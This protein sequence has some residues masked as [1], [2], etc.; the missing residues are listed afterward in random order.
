LP[1]EILQARCGS[2]A[3]HGHMNRPPLIVGGRLGEYGTGAFA[4][5]GALTA[6]RRY[7]LTGER[8]H[9]DVSML[10]AMHLTL[11][12]TPTLMARFPGG[13]Q[14]AFRFVMIPG[15]EP[16]RDGYV[17]ITT[18]TRQQW[19]A[20]LGVMGRDDLVEDEE[21]ATF[22]GRFMR[23]KE[24]NQAIHDWTEARTAEEI[25]DAC[26]A[27][28]VPVAVV[29]NGATLP[30]VPQLTARN[31]IV[32][33]PGASFVRPRAPFRFAAAPE[34]TMTPAPRLGE[35]TGDIPVPHRALAA[36]P[37]RDDDA[38]A[39]RPLAGVRVLDFTAFWAGPFATAWL[40][41]MG[42]EVVKVESVQRPDGIRFSAAVKPKD[43]AD[44][45]E[46][47]PL[48]HACNLGKRCITLDLGHADGRQLAR[49]LIPRFDVLV[50]NFTPPVMDGFGLT[51]DEVA[52]LRP[53]V[54][55]VRQPA[56]GLEGPWR[57]RPGFAQTMEQLT[58][59]AW[60]TGY[61]GGPPIIPGGFVDPLC[62]THAAMAVVAALEHRDRTGEG[63]LVEMPMIEV[64][65]AVTGEQIVEYSAYGALLD[66][67]GEHGVYQ[68][69]GDDAWIA[70][71]DG[72]DPMPAA[73]RAEWC[74]DREPAIAVGELET[75]GIAADVMVPGFAALDDLQMQA[76]GFFQAIEHPLVGEHEYPGFPIRFD[77]R[78]PG[79]WWPGRAPLL[80]EHT[81][82]VLRTELGLADDELARLRADNVI[83]TRP[84][85]S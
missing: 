48:F 69:A 21:L 52:A 14:H 59:M 39:G 49:D 8:D 55:M 13:R 70:V 84:L 37:R 65:A 34:L 85:P 72:N 73:E 68:C 66:R 57:D 5:L 24:V 43:D 1:E 18:I 23:A 58:G 44:Y 50:E 28:R 25:V 54:V 35:H 40:V 80:G 77:S 79:D 32:E 2:L 64:A 83:G 26:T 62:G 19:F 60:L 4:A 41:A 75:E 7:R 6:W 47:S 10:E 30:A 78:E 38:A 33:Q 16:C 36:R 9:V 15:N 29:G 82:E 20:L 74:A 67:R 76:R 56:F 12:T 45:Y 46:K 61:D 22:L 31:S 27:A 17:G 81:D 51:Y 71:D 3:N 53:D 11:L 63:Q 42:A